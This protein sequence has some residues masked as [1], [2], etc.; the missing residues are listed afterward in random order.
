MC[1]NTITF[2]KLPTARPSKRKKI[3][4]KT[5]SILH[6]QNDVQNTPR[7]MFVIRFDTSAES[8]G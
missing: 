2:I 4:N 1:L 5:I 8:S 7:G 3:N 6:I